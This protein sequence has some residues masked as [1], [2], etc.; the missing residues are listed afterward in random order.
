MALYQYK[1]EQCDY[2]EARLYPMGEQPAVTE[3]PRCFQDTLRRVFTPTHH[4]H[5]NAQGEPIRAPGS[6]WVGGDRFD[7][8]RFWKENPNACR[9]KAK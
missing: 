2:Q 4:R 1:C 3:C 6:E 9:K 5:V 7:S 8:S